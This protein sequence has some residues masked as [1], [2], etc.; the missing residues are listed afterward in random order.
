MKH[1]AFWALECGNGDALVEVWLL[2]RAVDIVNTS[3]LDDGVA[4]SCT[5]A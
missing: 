5:I 1:A 4:A 2:G 3:A